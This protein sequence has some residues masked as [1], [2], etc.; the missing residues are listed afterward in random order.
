M[1]I[2]DVT[3]VPDD[4]PLADGGEPGPGLSAFDALTRGAPAP[5]WLHRGVSAAWGLDPARVVLELI[6]VSENAT[7]RLDL[8]GRAAGVVRVSQPGYVGG[9]AAVASELAFVASLWQVPDLRVLQA[10]P[11]YRGTYTAQVRDDAGQA[12]TCVSTRFVT[13]SVLEDLED[14]APYYRTIGR[15]SALLHEHARTWTPPHAFTRFTWDVPDMVGP[16]A[17]WD[18]W[19]SAGMTSAEREL[20]LAAQD[21]AL[22]IVADFPADEQTWGLVHADLRPSNIIA[23]GGTLTVIDFDDCGWSYYLYDFAAALT[24]VEHEPYA[25]AMARAWV[26]GYQEVAPLSAG[27]LE[28]ACALSMLRRLQMLGWTLG[29]REDALP[30]G[31]HAAQKPGSLEVARR[32]LDRTTWLLA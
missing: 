7:F 25:P 29:H 5:Y 32:F 14:P 8:D 13:G 16:S 10:V 3:P 22:A 23:D 20:L 27:D 2:P 9:P 21:K 30:P 28:V 12:W 31:L 19:E 6:T 11:T 24:F 26:T 18:P 4:V 1:T 15:W 17:R